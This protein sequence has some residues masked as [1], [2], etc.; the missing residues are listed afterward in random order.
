[1]LVYPK[2]RRV[3]IIQKKGSDDLIPGRSVWLKGRNLKKRIKD[4]LPYI[5]LERV[6]YM[7][8]KPKLFSYTV[9]E[10]SYLM[11]IRRVKEWYG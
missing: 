5:V 10:L 11:F 4:P 8:E 6:K 7:G 1:M 3:E 2:S 9:T